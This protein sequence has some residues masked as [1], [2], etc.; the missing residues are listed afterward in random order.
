MLNKK[1]HK[2]IN[3][4]NP[5]SFKPTSLFGDPAE[6][7]GTLEHNLDKNT[8]EPGSDG[9]EIATS[10]GNTGSKNSVGRSHAYT[11]SITP[12]KQNNNTK[13]TQQ[14]SGEAEQENKKNKE[15]SSDI[16]KSEQIRVVHS[17]PLICVSPDTVTRVVGFQIPQVTT[18]EPTTDKEKI[19]QDNSATS[20]PTSKQAGTGNFIFIKEKPLSYVQKVKSSLHDSEEKI[21]IGNIR[22][23]NQGGRG[24]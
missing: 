20:E 14:R 19:L 17:A 24:C 2:G 12:R 9:T 16:K 15:H 22:I 21:Q 8:P 3:H 1:Q 4:C 13:V 11:N 7:Y 18:Q 23:N 6:A 5:S 10:S